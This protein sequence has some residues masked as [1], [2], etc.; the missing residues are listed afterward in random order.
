MTTDDQRPAD[1]LPA[2]DQLP[3]H[4]GAP[5]IVPGDLPHDPA[6]L[7]VIDES[8]TGRG[9]GAGEAQEVAGLSQGQIVWGRFLRHKGAMG[10][11]GVLLFIMLFSSSAMGVGPIPGLVAVQRQPAGHA[12][13]DQRRRAHDHPA[14]VVGRNR[15]RAELR[16]PPVRPGQHRHATTSPR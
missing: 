14:D 7:E 11:L 1:D 3:S 10:G 5:G 13:H 12:R 15:P 2:D 6:E 9:E 4:Q 8:A 16:R